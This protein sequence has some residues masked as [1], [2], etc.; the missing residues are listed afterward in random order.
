LR[1]I[2]IFKPPLQLLIHPT[3]GIDNQNYEPIIKGGNKSARH[4]TRYTNRV[5][6]EER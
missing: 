3:L 4:T 5:R 2:A 6:D 1:S